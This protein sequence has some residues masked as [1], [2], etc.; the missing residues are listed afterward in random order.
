LMNTIYTNTPGVIGPTGS[1]GATGAVGPVGL[2]G[3]MGPTGQTGPT[4]ADGYIGSTADGSWISYNLDPTLTMH[5]ML[6]TADVSGNLLANN[7]NGKPVYDA[8]MSASNLIVSLSSP[9]ANS[10]G[11]LSLFSPSGQYV[12]VPSL[13]ASF[14][15]N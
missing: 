5:Y 9:A 11:S 14:G 12:Q 3:P 7:A 13:P 2:I 6:N 10:A 8:S 15:T 4:G 1:T